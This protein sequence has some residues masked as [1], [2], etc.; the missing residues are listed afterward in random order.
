MIRIDAVDELGEEIHVVDPGSNPVGPIDRC[1]PVVP[2]FLDAFRK[3]HEPST[4]VRFAQYLT[5]R[6][7]VELL[8]GASP[9]V[10]GQY[11]GRRLASR[12]PG[13]QVQVIGAGD[14]LVL[15]RVGGK[16]RAGSPA[17]RTGCTRDAN[18][19]CAGQPEFRK[20]A[21]PSSR[22]AHSPRI[23]GGRDAERDFGAPETTGRRQAE[24]ALDRSK[25]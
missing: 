9:S 5:I 20:S 13:G 23:A 25:A 3:S 22:R 11:E 17:A 19:N 7:T 8:A 24:R 18:R 14:A 12:M 6:G 16:R 4:G 2:T 21:V 1:S 15:E 10:Q